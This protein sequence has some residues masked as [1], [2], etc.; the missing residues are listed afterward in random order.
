MCESAIAC[1]LVSVLMYVCVIFVDVCWCGC[2]LYMC[3]CEYTNINVHVCLCV[4]RS[5]YAYV[6][7]ILCFCGWV[8]VDVCVC[9]CVC[10]GGTVNIKVIDNK[11]W[12]NTDMEGNEG[13]RETLSPYNYPSQIDISNRMRHPYVAP[14]YTA[15]PANRW[16]VPWMTFA[17]QRARSAPEYISLIRVG[18][19]KIFQT[20]LIIRQT[21]N[22]TGILIFSTRWRASKRQLNEFCVPVTH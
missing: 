21:P 10:G 15:T 2:V 9:V 16:R 8:G 4:W 6:R 1:L 7:V 3:V 14:G 5:V 18:Q 11:L 22:R 17:S 20:G 13:I 12:L 19:C